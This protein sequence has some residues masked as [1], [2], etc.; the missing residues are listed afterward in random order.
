MEIDIIVGNIYTFWF[1]SGFTRIGTVR[2]ISDDQVYVEWNY[3]G[4]NPSWGQKDRII[5]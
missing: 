4:L 1:G 2:N 5:G 3:A